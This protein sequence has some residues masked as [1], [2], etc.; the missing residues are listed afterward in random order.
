MSAQNTSY[1]RPRGGRSP[2]ASAAADALTQSCRV[3][4]FGVDIA[5][6]AGRSTGPRVAG[7]YLTSTIARTSHRRSLVLQARTVSGRG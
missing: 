5:V 4:E 6:M 3:G 7:H 2:A 1:A